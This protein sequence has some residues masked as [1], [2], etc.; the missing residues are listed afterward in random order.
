MQGDQDRKS[1]TGEWGELAES[2]FE[3]GETLSIV[4]DP[5]LSP[6]GFDDEPAPKPVSRVYAVLQ[7]WMITQATIVRPWLLF[8]MRL[9]QLRAAIAI[10]DFAEHAVGSVHALLPYARRPLVA[11]RHPRLAHAS[12]VLLFSAAVNYCVVGVFATIGL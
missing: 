3:R 9:L 6:V 10:T 7:A 12:R 8:R 2:F 5:G 11:V 1:D 4:D